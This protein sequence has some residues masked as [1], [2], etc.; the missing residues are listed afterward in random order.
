MA[1][2]KKRHLQ[3]AIGIA[4][5]AVVLGI[6]VVILLV[7]LLPQEPQAPDGETDSSE[8]VFYQPYQGDILENELYL[9]LDRQLYW[10]DTLY[11][12]KEALDD[13]QISADPCLTLIRAYL[14]SL[15]GGDAEGC[16]SLFTVSALNAAP[17]SEFA[18]QMLY[19]IEIR[20][21]TQE[22]E[23][24]A[25]RVTYR[26]DYMI[27]R[28]NGTYRRD[29]GSDAVRPEYLTIIEIADGEYRIDGIRR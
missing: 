17:I 24:G 25:K 19:R 6:A 14:D 12:S 5:G 3:I 20:L 29:V 16:R 15:I 13:G 22:T 4:V 27:H 8:F 18:Q 9:S 11:N 28:N 1:A 10:C 23:N 21:I 7:L 26:L 2:E